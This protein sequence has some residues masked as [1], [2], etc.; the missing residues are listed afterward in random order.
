MMGS[1]ED[2]LDDSRGCVLYPQAFMR[3]ALTRSGSYSTAWSQNEN[4]A[5][6]ARK[7]PHATAA[8]LFSPAIAEFAQMIQKGGGRQ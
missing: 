2:S 7:R 4:K 8:R 1:P 6:I 5:H 3:N